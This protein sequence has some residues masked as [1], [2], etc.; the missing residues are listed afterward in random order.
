MRWSHMDVAMAQQRLEVTI[1]PLVGNVGGRLV[2]QLRAVPGRD[3]RGPVAASSAAAVGVRV[4]TRSPDSE[5]P[6]RPQTRLWG[7]SCNSD[8][9]SRSVVIHQIAVDIPVM[10]APRA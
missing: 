7:R 4:P 8:P 5:S 6:P 1:V 10:T 3:G 2:G 9:N